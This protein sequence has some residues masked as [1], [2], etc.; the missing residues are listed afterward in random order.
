MKTIL[1]LKHKNRLHL[2]VVMLL[3]CLFS[4]A[5]C[6][7]RFKYT[8]TLGFSFLL[9]NLFLAGIPLA[10]STILYIRNPQKISFVFF[11]LMISGWLL[12]FPNSPYILTDMLHLRE[13]P[14][15]PIWYDVLMMV[16]FA[17]NGFIM[18]LISLLDI[19]QLIADR[20][21][22]ITGWL[23][24]GFSICLGSFGI[25]LGR[26]ERWNSWDI[27]TNPFALMADIANQVLHPNAHH[28]TIVVTFLFSVFIGIAYYMLRLLTT[29]KS[30]IVDR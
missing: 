29:R 7:F 12:F 11:A 5:L 16:S 3:S 20:I 10:I 22:K 17:W 19:Q 13:R 27:I 30:L 14:P 26:F 2:S 4:I 15:V 1:L 28:R 18:G 6:F 9:W 24:A 8:H 21:G 25:Y 23:F